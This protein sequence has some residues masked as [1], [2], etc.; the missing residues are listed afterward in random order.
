MSDLAT[1]LVVSGMKQFD[2]VRVS[3]ALGLPPTEIWRRKEGLKV[4]GLDTIPAMSWI[5]EKTGDQD[6][7]LGEMLNALLDQVGS[8][9]VLLTR[10]AIELEL[11]VSVICRIVARDPGQRVELSA[12]TLSRLASMKCATILSVEYEPEDVGENR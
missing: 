2:P 9:S 11:T 7:S 4:H 12:E 6:D 5:L 1:S 3:G 10:L 8:R